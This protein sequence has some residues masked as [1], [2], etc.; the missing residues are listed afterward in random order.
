[1]RLFPRRR[2]TGSSVPDV[3]PAQ[4]RAEVTAHF[5]DFVA[6]RAGVEAYIE[7][8]TANDP[9]T[10]VLVARTGEWT[11]RRIPDQKAAWAL[12]RELEIPVYDVN[13]TGYPSS[14]RRWSA[15]QRRK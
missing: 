5:R 11:R 2:T 6:T 3:S 1:M 14:M 8:P 15:A 9:T 13:L 7:P 4:R 10:M 12:A